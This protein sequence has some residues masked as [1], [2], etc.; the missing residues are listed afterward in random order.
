MISVLKP[1]F[2]RRVMPDWPE[3]NPRP[4]ADPDRSLLHAYWPSKDDHK[5]PVASAAPPEVGLLPRHMPSVYF[6]EKIPDSLLSAVPRTVRLRPAGNKKWP[7]GRLKDFNKLNLV[8]II[9]L[10]AVELIESLAPGRNQF[11][12]ID[13]VRA[14]TDAPLFEGERYYL[15]NVCDTVRADR[16]FPFEAFERNLH[17]G[18]YDYLDEGTFAHKFKTRQL[19]YRFEKPLQEGGRLLARCASTLRFEL[20]GKENQYLVDQEA[21]R[22]VP[23]FVVANHCDRSNGQ[24]RLYAASYGDLFVTETFRDAVKNAKLTGARYEGCISLSDL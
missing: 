4:I 5:V 13:F 12:P 21:A 18:L 3:L 6:G 1:D 19:T 20:H 24:T 22:D 7:V 10:R 16:L 15:L 11:F 17:A 2:S 23:I 14:T 8:P 9:S